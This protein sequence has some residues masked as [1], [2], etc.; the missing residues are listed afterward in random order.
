MVA[1]GRVV[2]VGWDW[3]CV[4]VALGAGKEVALGA[5]VALGG[6]AG[7]G[8][9]VA[10]GRTTTSVA[11]SLVAV[12][13]NRGRRNISPPVTRIA[14]SA[15]PARMGSQARLEAGFGLATGAATQAW[16]G[17]GCGWTGGA[18]IVCGVAAMVAACW[19]CAKI[20]CGG[21]NSALRRSLTRW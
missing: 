6:G 7:G 18:I 11:G 5:V 3:L 12:A 13:A 16:A 21:C 19:V 15:S 10:A 17:G 8:V 9:S 14:T 1:D 4:R 20:G 2:A